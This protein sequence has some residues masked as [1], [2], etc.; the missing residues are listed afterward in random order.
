MELT[1]TLVEPGVPCVFGHA[2]AWRGILSR[3]QSRDSV[4]SWSS[5]LRLLTGHPLERHFGSCSAAGML[6]L[7]R[8]PADKTYRPSARQSSSACL[9]QSMTPQPIA[10]LT[11]AA[12]DYFGGGHECMLRL[13]SEWEARDLELARIKPHV[14][15]ALV[16]SKRKY[17]SVA[18]KL[19]G[20]G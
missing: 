11:D 5:R 14:D 1:G 2:M 15:P 17:I 6:T 9:G 10:S 3:W 20:S 8:A 19:V 16:R 18:K 7:V 12:N 13:D 4:Q